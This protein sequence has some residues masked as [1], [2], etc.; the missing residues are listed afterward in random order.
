[1]IRQDM[2][3][4]VEVMSKKALKELCSLAQ[5][6]QD[7]D[8]VY[9]ENVREACE[10]GRHHT[11]LSDV[12]AHPNYIDVSANDEREAKQ[13]IER[14]LPKKKG[15]VIKSLRPCPYDGWGEDDSWR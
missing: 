15:Y 5:C 12:W 7:I 6:I 14:N 11:E 1:M 4:L 13:K 3:E 2:D 9:N 10:E 8:A